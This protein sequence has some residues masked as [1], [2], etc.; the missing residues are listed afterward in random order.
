MAQFSESEIDAAKKRV[1]EMQNR[2]SKYTTR[3]E[4]PNI[5]PSAP[6]SEKPSEKKHRAQTNGDKKPKTDEDENEEQDKS[7][8]IILALILLL[9][10]EGA[11]NTLIL[12]LLYL[13]L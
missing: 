3:N 1:W 5:P 8:A 12:A 6:V 9:S 4:K 13:L 10:K 2:A 11:D 7:L